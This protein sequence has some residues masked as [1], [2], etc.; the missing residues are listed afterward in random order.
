MILVAHPGDRFFT[1]K[2]TDTSVSP[3]IIV[4]HGSPARLGCV[5]ARGCGSEGCGN[6]GV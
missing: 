2:N 4:T 6:E 3:V 5:V 1:L